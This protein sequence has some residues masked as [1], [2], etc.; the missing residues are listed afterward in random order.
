[1]VSVD[2]RLAPEHP[3][4]ARLDDC[5]AVTGALAEKRRGAAAG[6]SASGNLVAVV[7]NTV[8]VAVQ[9]L[10]YPLTG[11]ARPWRHRHLAR[12]A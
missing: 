12:P 4:P 10:M 1:M 7:A 9:F 3:V 5:V 8:P 11:G 6:D 2:Y